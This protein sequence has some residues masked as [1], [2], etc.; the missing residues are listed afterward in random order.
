MVLAN[1]RS[2]PIDWAATNPPNISTTLLDMPK[3]KMLA[4][5]TIV[6]VDPSTRRLSCPLI[7]EPVRNLL[8]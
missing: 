6:S 7:L 8:L 3:E 2:P 1:L 5:T 4:T